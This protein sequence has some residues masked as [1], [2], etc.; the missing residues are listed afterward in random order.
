MCLSA[1]LERVFQSET[2]DPGSSPNPVRQK[3][4]LMV[5]IKLF[6]V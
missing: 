4:S 5:T 3:N 6:F 2:E 1:E